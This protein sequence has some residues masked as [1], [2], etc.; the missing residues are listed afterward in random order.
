MVAS[1]GSVATHL[2]CHLIIAAT[3]YPYDKINLNDVWAEVLNRL[4]V[5][6]GRVHIAQFVSSELV[7]LSPGQAQILAPTLSAKQVIETRIHTLRTVL[8]D[9]LNWP[10]ITIRVVLQRSGVQHA[11]PV[12]P[13]AP[14][15][16][17]LLDH[18]SLPSCPNWLPASLW[19]AFPALLRLALENATYDGVAIHTAT[20]GMMRVL[21]HYT[22]QIAEII[23][24]LKDSANHTE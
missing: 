15:A 12:I 17:T 3:N 4:R 1:F 16:L 19:T 9:I 18:P 8:M 5:H 2:I 6:I 7:G 10:E 24:V 14:S 22:E 20:S 23:Q 21:E 13:T 11:A